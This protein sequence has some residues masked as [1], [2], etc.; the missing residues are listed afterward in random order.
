[1]KL[2][3]KC[4]ESR[5]REMRVERGGV[6]WRK[7]GGG[8]GC[9]WGFWCF[10]VSKLCNPSPHLSLHSS[11]LPQK[12]QRFSLHPTSSH[13][14]KLYYQTP[15]IYSLIQYSILHNLLFLSTS[16]HLLLYKMFHVKQA[17][18]LLKTTSIIPLEDSSPNFSYQF[19]NLKISF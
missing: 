7:V 10:V 8:M 1:M 6:K 3:G 5:R 15:L 18:L 2:G 14:S 4:D 9:G 11:P 13:K 16:S 17:I 19:S 12:N